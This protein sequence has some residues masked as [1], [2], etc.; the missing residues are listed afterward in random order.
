MVTFGRNNAA[1]TSNRV[2]VAALLVALVAA[3]AT[4][5]SGLIQTHSRPILGSYLVELAPGDGINA[6][7]IAE[8]L[9]RKHHVNIKTVWQDALQGF[10]IEA[11]E[12]AAIEISRDPRVS[13]V[14]QDASAEM[15]CLQ[16]SAG[17]A[18]NSLPWQLDRIDQLSPFLDGQFASCPEAGKGVTIYVIDSGIRATHHDFYD[19]DQKSRVAEGVS[20]V[21]DGHGTDD[22]YSHGTYVASMAGGKDSGVAKAATLVPV[23][24]GDCQGNATLTQVINAV[25]WV[26][27]HHATPAVANI[28]MVFSYSRSLDDAVTK[29]IGSGV[30]VTVAAGNNASDA[31]AFSPASNPKVLT[32]GASDRDDNVASFSNLGSCVQLFAPGVGVGGAHFAQDGYWNCSPGWNGTSVAAPLVAGVAASLL[33]QYP[34]MSPGDVK[35]MVLAGATANALHM[36]KGYG[37]SPNRLLH[38]LL[39][40]CADASCDTQTSPVSPANTT[41]PA[42]RRHSSGR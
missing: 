31:C 27:Q 42:P 41:T 7:A 1:V 39:N 19:S 10:V 24:V 4:A 35:A 9:A 34:T 20:F 17:C 11:P 30:V 38:T 2:F 14:E 29:L 36:P 37:S 16:K 33:S 13:A 21:N 25:N 8:E 22:C 6:Q 5:G 12:Q 18:D 15:A 40:D 3:T 32:V 26:V 23:R 28:S